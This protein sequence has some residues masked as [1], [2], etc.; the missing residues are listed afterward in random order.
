MERMNMRMT[1]RSKWKSDKE[2]LR[3]LGMFSSEK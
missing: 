3:E 2:W 1:E